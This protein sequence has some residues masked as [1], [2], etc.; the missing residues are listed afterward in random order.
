MAPQVSIIGAGIAGLVLG[1]CLRRRSIPATI[2]EKSKQIPALQ[3]F[4]ITLQNHVGQRLV[5]EL[6]LDET[7]FINDNAVHSKSDPN[8]PLRVNRSAFLRTLAKDL[9][10]K[11]DHKLTG[12]SRGTR[13]KLEFEHDGAKQTYEAELVFVTDGV[14][15]AARNSLN[16]KKD[17]FHLEVLPFVVYNGKRRFSKEKLPA[18][19]EG[20]L[21]PNGISH[22]VNSVLLQITS[23]YSTREEL[24]INYTLSRPAESSDDELLGRSNADAESLARRFLD[25]ASQL[26]DLQEP[27]K[28]VFDPVVMKDDRLLHWLMRSALID[29]STAEELVHKGVV[30]LGDAASPQP[31]LGGYGAN[32]AIMDAFAIAKATDPSGSVNIAAYRDLHAQWKTWKAD[33][34]QAIG[35]MHRPSARASI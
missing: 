5:Q 24:A 34:E 16:I 25:E 20:C 30:L 29:S 22:L 2:F 21:S 10:I 23:G 35:D 33:A 1:Q 14:H 28:S 15:S 17:A 8:G 12:L 7:A 4:G 19:L 31:I 11:W 26:P 6:D 27:F 18:D 32:A 3:N 13:H 9:D